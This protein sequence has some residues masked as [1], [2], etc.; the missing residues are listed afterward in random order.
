MTSSAMKN[1]RSLR[2]I[3]KPGN[4][5]AGV[6]STKRI[7]WILPAA[8]L[9]LLAPMHA[10]AQSG[11][12]RWVF[13]LTPYLWLPSMEGSLRY[14]PPPTGG[15]APNVSVDAEDILS[16]LDFAFMFT[17]DAR[18]GR[19][20]I[21]TDFMYVSLSSDKAAVKSVD[22]NPGAGPVNFATGALTLGAEVEFK[23]TIWTLAG[24]Y[25]LLHEPRVTLD[26]IGGFRYADLEATTNYQLSA[27][28][29]GPAGAGT[30]AR[31]GSVT[32]SQNIW[33]A[34][35]GIRGR[36]K[37]GEGNWFVPYHLDVGAGDSKLTWQGVVGV[38]YS[39]K[40]GDI[41]LT[42]RYLSYEVGG[43]KLIEDMVLKGPALGALF[44]F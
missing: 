19:W 25:S 2:S 20:S 31:T 24:G 27:T 3:W 9:S 12:D 11:E 4:I 35:V 42:Y 14:G 36:F 34:I 26:L 37:L 32:K 15:S 40:W 43:N 5:N 39:Y 44:R 7:A 23:G 38:G 17:A 21:L 10:V 28:V 41:G 1:G 6:I 29:T 16:S 8:V 30:F 13:S 33:D 18:K 22:F